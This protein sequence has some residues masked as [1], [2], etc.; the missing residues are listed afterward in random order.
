MQPHVRRFRA[1]PCCEDAALRLECCHQL[2]IRVRLDSLRHSLLR[3][4]SIL[5]G[6]LVLDLDIFG[7]EDE[8]VAARRDLLKSQYRDRLH[9]KR[10]L[11]CG[12]DLGLH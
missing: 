11:E 5:E 8:S 2:R 7:G 4:R 10:G 9:P 1:F 3:R 12:G 6:H